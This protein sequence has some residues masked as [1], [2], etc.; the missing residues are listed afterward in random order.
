MVGGTCAGNYSCT[1]EL[2]KHLDPQPPTVVS[3]TKTQKFTIV[4][5][6]KHVNLET[7]GEVC[8]VLESFLGQRLP[9][10]RCC[11]PEQCIHPHILFSKKKLSCGTKVTHFCEAKQICNA[12]HHHGLEGPLVNSAMQ[13]HLIVHSKTHSC[14]LNGWKL[15]G[16]IKNK[17]TIISLTLMWST[18]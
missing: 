11:L 7:S 16:K 9:Y 13:C 8:Q 18:L 1:K 5:R 14:V 6:G 4:L 17:G 2:E 10:C 3:L 12:D 15:S